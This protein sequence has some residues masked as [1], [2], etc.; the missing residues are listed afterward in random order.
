[1]TCV[2]EIFIL[3][4]WVFTRN[5]FD[6]MIGLRDTF[7]SFNFIFNRLLPTPEGSRFSV[8]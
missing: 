6:A 4:Y 8:E 5:Q 1:M 3:K 7:G 2:A